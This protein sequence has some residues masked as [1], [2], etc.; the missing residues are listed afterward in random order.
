MADKLTLKL[1]TPLAEVVAG[2]ADMVVLPAHHGELG[3]LPGHD[4]YMALLSVGALRM[5]SGTDTRV[6]FVANGYAEVGGDEVRVL[7][8][9]CEPVA[10]IDVARAKS[11][12]QR[13]EE[14]LAKSASDADIDIRRAQAALTRALMRQTL[15]GAGPH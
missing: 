10:S 9:V 2:E 13:A 12:Q 4:R 1:V 8:E 11:A 15:A 3:V 14:R 7:A 5:T 6:F